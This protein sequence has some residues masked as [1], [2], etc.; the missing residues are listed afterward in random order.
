MVKFSDKTVN[1]IVRLVEVFTVAV[2]YI[3]F[4]NGLSLDTLIVSFFGFCSVELWSLAGITKTKVI[5]KGG[6]DV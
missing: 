5:N 3:S 2:L 1:K 4:K 6:D